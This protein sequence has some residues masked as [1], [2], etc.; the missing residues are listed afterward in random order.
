MTLSYES[1]VLVSWTWWHSKP[2]NTW[3][4]LCQPAV[5]WAGFIWLFVWAIRFWS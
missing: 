2:S 4:P 1:I 5:H 3:V